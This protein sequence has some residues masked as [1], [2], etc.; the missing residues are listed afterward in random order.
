VETESRTHN[1]SSAPPDVT[2]TVIV[3]LY[4]AER[5]VEETLRSVLAQS[6]S[7]LELIVVDDGSSDGS[8]AIVARIARADPRLR[9]LTL[10]N[11]GAAVARDTGLRTACGRYVAFLDHDD[12]WYPAKLEKQIRALDADPQAVGIG[13]LMDYVT[14]D[15]RRFGATAQTPDVIDRSRV[16]D[17]A[18]LPFPLSSALLRTEAVRAVGGI[19]DLFGPG[20]VLTEDLHLLARLARHGRLLCLRER[21]GGYRV[22]GSSASNAAA[23]ELFPATE[24][25]RRALCDPSFPGRV[26]WQ[27]F[28]AEYRPSRREL[29]FQRAQVRYRRGLLALAEGRFLHGSAGLSAA[30]ITRPD[31]AIPR[32]WRQLRRR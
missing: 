14:A 32:A 3:P 12:V 10:A 7:D 26:T 5:Y 15:G 29:R 11:S 18:L 19:C 23:M 30:L 24:Y 17:G 9:L 25:V 16:A 31:Y 4:N 13:C 8:A 28:L 20:R 22:H 27:A 21:L 1:E 2:V 6:A